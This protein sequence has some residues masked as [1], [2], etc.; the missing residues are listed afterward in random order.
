MKSIALFI[1]TA[2]TLGLVSRSTAAGPSGQVNEGPAQFVQRFYDWYVPVAAKTD[3]EPPLAVALRARGPAF[4]PTLRKAL[5]E[6]LAAE[7]KAS[8]EIVGLDFDPFLNS[9]DVVGPCHVG[10]VRHKGSTYWVDIY[11]DGP[12]TPKAKPIVVAELM[13]SGRRWHFK[14]FLYPD[15]GDR[16]THILKLLKMDREKSH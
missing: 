16:L 10:S 12:G 9:Q 2:L 1:A 7:K 15:S 13:K 11:T 6:D 5:A 14:D 8:G 3:S 4:A